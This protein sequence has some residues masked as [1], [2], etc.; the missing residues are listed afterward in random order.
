VRKYNTKDLSDSEV[1]AIQVA[2]S[3]MSKATNGKQPTRFGVTPGS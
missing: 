3:E 1:W 2:R